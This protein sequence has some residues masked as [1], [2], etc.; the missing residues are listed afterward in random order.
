MS[1][2]LFDWEANRFKEITKDFKIKML[3]VKIANLVYDLKNNISIII[4]YTY[5]RYPRC[6][7]LS[8][9]NKCLIYQ[10]RPIICRMWPCPYG[11]FQP[12]N[13][14]SSSKVCKSELPI[15]K[16][17]KELKMNKNFTD[18]II[19]DEVKENLSKRYKENY[20]YR[21]I[22]DEL[23]ELIMNFIEDQTQ[24]GKIKPARK[25]HNLEFLF[26]KIKKSQKVNFS[27]LFYNNT[28]KKIQEQIKFS[29]NEKDFLKI[30]NKF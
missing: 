18:N 17:H 29:T 4:H 23:N 16:L 12:K 27:D 20:K 14:R 22:F 26:K 10:N 28:G 30:Q 1:L 7:F 15:D 21:Y 2:G 24:K 3:D 9:E 11:K 13:L 19:S 8:N 5:D 6:K 25:G